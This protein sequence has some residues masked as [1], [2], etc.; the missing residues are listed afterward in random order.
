MMLPRTTRVTA[1]DQLARGDEVI[2]ST[3]ALVDYPNLPF[4]D[5]LTAT[6]N[7]RGYVGKY[8]RKG[9]VSKLTDNGGV[10]LKTK[11]GRYRRYRCKS[12]IPLARVWCRNGRVYKAPNVDKLP[13][14]NADLKW[15]R[16][17][18]EDDLK[19]RQTYLVRQN[20]TG[21]AQAKVRLKLN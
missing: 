20:L 3:R 16:Q 12:W 19:W 6:L 4:Y 7:P 1:I 15:Q 8:L 2:Y 17:Q 10:L 5:C 13:W 9:I 14:A 21:W 18:R 11:S